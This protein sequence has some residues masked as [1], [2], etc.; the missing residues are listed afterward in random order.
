VRREDA[1]QVVRRLAAVAQELGQAGVGRVRADRY[2]GKAIVPFVA[3]LE[4]RD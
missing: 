2:L 3:R 4:K 1:A